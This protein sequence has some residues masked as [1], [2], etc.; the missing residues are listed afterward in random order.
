MREKRKKGGRPPKEFN[1]KE[2]FNLKNQKVFSE[3]KKSLY[4]N[5]NDNVNDKSSS[6]SSFDAHIKNDVITEDEK[7]YLKSHILLNRKDVK[8]VTAYANKMIGNGDY[9][10]IITKYRNEKLEQK[11]LTELKEEKEKLQKQ[12]EIEF[13]QNKKKE[14]EEKN[15]LIKEQIKQINDKESC[16]KILFEYNEGIDAP[17]E[18]TKFKKTYNLDTPE[19]VRK[20]FFEA[21]HKNHKLPPTIFSTEV[22]GQ[23]DAHL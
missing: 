8:D 7:N 21:L 13:L 12:K 1:E 2:Q 3:S 4:D 9:L 23:P 15:K 22:T 19:K 18:F 20:T 16:A 14:K 6:S 11:M 10:K 5:D 17:K